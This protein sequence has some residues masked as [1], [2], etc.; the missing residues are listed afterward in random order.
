MGWGAN[1]RRHI[2]RRSIRHCALVLTI[3]FFASLR[4]ANGNLFIERI[5]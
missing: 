2:S 4:F 5:L 1:Y 3:Y